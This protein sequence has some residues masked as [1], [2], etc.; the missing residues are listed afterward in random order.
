MPTID[1][2]PPAPRLR[3]NEPVTLTDDRTFIGYFVGVMLDAAGQPTGEVLIS[4]KQPGKQFGVQHQLKVKRDR[5][6]PIKQ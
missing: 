2:N 6:V 1:L 5:V 3:F 4:V